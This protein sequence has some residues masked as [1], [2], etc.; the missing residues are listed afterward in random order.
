MKRARGL[1]SPQ[2]GPTFL[3]NEEKGCMEQYLLKS[4]R[5]GDEFL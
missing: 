2:R 4:V 1:P 3:G 5:D